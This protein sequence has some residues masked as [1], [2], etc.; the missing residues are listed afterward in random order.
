MMFYSYSHRQYYGC[1]QAQKHNDI[2][3]TISKKTTKPWNSIIENT[4]S[5][6]KTQLYVDVFF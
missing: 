5:N 3:E 6:P 2:S 1:P 4:T